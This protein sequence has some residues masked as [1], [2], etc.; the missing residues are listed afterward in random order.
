MSDAAE[1]VAGLVGAVRTAGRP[2]LVGIAG[3]VSVGKTTLAEQLRDR[4]PDRTDVVGTDGFLFPTRVLAT[5]GLTNRKG[6]PESYDVEALRAFL[7]A[8]RAGGFPREVPCYSHETYDVDGERTVDAVDTLIVEGLNILS[9]GADVLDVGVY[10]DA[11]EATLEAWY[12]QRFRALV[13]EA[14]HDPSSFYRSFGG[15]DDDSIAAVADSVWQS[16]NLV[17]LRD[18]VAPSRVRADCVIT[19]GPDHS[20]VAVDH[21]AGTAGPR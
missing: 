2:V 20:I 11:P 4:L 5:R 9:V 14:E 17:N 15:M 13:R 6:F 18:H 10:L 12:Q 16:I 3:G 8:A 1:V 19:K 21:Q 7:L